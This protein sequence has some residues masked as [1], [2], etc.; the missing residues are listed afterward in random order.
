MSAKSMKATNGFSLRTLMLTVTGF[1]ILC[2]VFAAH[3][4]NATMAHLL[5]VLAFAIPGGS[6]GY[7]L[8]RSSRN[9]A[10]GTSVAA[11]VGTI[12]LS[13]RVLIVDLLML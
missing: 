12:A 5:L 9:V 10:V 11:V 3:G 6:Y 7:D 2:G 4:I 1:A 8:G 13:A